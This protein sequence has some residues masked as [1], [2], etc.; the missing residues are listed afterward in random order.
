M[1]IAMTDYNKKFVYIKV[2]YEWLSRLLY[3]FENRRTMHAQ[4]RKV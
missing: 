2:M 3:K 4:E 1:T